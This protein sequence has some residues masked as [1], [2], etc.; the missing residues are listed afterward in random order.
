VERGFELFPEK[1]YESDTLTAITN[2]KG[3][4]VADV[5][6]KLEEK[7]ITIS[8]GYGDIKEK[9]FRIAHMGDTKLDEIKELLEMMNE[10]LG[11]G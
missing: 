8:N 7:G 3:I 6:K 9:T 11:G 1:G 5:I 10:I 4:V 2:N